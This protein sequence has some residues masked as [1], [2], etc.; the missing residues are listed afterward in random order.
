MSSLTDLIPGADL[1][2]LGMSIIDKIIP[3]PAAKA[4]A[5]L[6]LLNAE[7]EGRMEETKLQM[8]AI[9][10]E[11]QSEDK[12]TSRARPSF[13]YV[14]YV[15]I[16]AGIPMGILYAVSPS[17]AQNV[18]DG[19]NAWL[20]AIP[21]RIVD[22]FQWVMLGYITSRGVEKGISMVKGAK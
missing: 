11:A 17:T 14:V 22:L 10:A 18:A 20:S 4:K 13:L 7:R 8:S 2:K 3:D 16:L 21:D 9:M 19:F 1:V 6:D 15:L 12:W 5:Q